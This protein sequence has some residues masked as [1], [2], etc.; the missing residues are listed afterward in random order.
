MSF[1]VKVL[2]FP[3]QR[4]NYQQLAYSLLLRRSGYEAKAKI[5]IDNE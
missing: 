3:A 5:Q 2:Q 4:K 1:L